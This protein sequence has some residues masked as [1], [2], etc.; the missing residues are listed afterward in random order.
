MKLKLG[1]VV[2]VVILL[3][4]CGGGFVGDSFKSLAVS[5]QTYEAT[6][7]S[8]GDLYKEGVLSDEAKDKAVEYGRKYQTAHNSAVDA[9]MT[10]VVADP[11][12]QEDSKEAY[13]KLFEGLSVQ[14]ADLIK[15]LTEVE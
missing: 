5:K 13:L 8:L 1:V 3:A 2:C 14:L 12:N 11:E 15:I 4:G 10:Y 7:T 9:L 6:M